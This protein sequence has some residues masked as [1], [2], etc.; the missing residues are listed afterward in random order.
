MSERFSSSTES[1]R[2][3]EQPK[4]QDTIRQAVE[5][6]RLTEAHRE[7]SAEGL[8]ELINEPKREG[9]TALE[10]IARIITEEAQSILEEL[11][12]ELAFLSTQLQEFEELKG[13]TKD[14][15]EKIGRIKSLNSHNRKKNYFS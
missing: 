3:P 6:M 14:D 15:Q 1:Q 12:G 2:E 10:A 9:E 4:I 5:K 13:K 8:L 11:R 7:T